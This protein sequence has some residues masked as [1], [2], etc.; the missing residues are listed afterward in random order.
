MKFT[1]QLNLIIEGIGSSRNLHQSLPS[2][3]IDKDKK[4]LRMV[5]FL[6]G[7]KKLIQYVNEEIEDLNKK[8]KIKIPFYKLEIQKDVVNSTVKKEIMNVMYDFI[9]DLNIDLFKKK[10]IKILIILFKEQNEYFDF[11][12]FCE[13]NIKNITVKI[14][15]TDNKYSLNRIIISDPNVSYK[16]FIHDL[17]MH[18]FL[19]PKD[20]QK[21]DISI[22]I[23]GYDFISSHRFSPGSILNELIA[24][25]TDL[26]KNNHLIKNDFIK[27]IKNDFKKIIEKSKTDNSDIKEED[28]I[29]EIFNLK[30]KLLVQKLKNIL[31]DDKNEDFNFD[32][33]K[34]IYISLNNSIYKKYFK[35]TLNYYIDKIISNERISN[36]SGYIKNKTI[37]NE[38]NIIEKNERPF[39]EFI[40][41]VIESILFRKNKFSKDKNQKVNWKDFRTYFK[42]YPYVLKLFPE[43]KYPDNKIIFDYTKTKYYL[44][45]IDP[46]EKPELVKIN[47]I[48]TNAVKIGQVLTK[49]TRTSHF[50]IENKEDKIDFVIERFINFIK[51]KFNDNSKY[52][53]LIDKELKS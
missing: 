25:Q 34:T 35:L 3:V 48:I 43:S 5:D 38:Q 15:S 27:S 8:E 41:R 2:F 21:F 10:L 51:N 23:D 22:G 33:I 32:E 45:D 37:D 9:N 26:F 12:D 19:N 47:N 29:N 46:E 11:Y 6:Y 31:L 53:A 20:I 7:L 44:I 18:T 36:L 30:N 39:Y 14:T 42:D 24:L 4:F 52:Y 16:S 17:V 50:D 1:Q 28:F 49:K 13:N 40:E